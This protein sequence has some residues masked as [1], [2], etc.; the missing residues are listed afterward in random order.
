MIPIKYK[1]KNAMLQLS[2]EITLLYQGDLKKLFE[3]HHPI[4]KTL[5]PDLLGIHV[6]ELTIFESKEFQVF[7]TC[8]A[9]LLRKNIMFFEKSYSLLQNEFKGYISDEIFVGQPS[10]GE[11]EGNNEQY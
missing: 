10:S 9:R 6:D 1:S 4:F 2:K 8:I 3:P 11:K 5:L 7:C